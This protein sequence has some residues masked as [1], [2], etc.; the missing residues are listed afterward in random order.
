MPSII[1][2]RKILKYFKRKDVEQKD[3]KINL[4]QAK[5]D[6]KLPRKDIIYTVNYYK[7]KNVLE[8]YP[9]N[10]TNVPEEFYQDFVSI[11]KREKKK[12]EIPSF[13]SG[14]VVAVLGGIILY[15][16]QYL[17]KAPLECLV[18]NLYG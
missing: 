9:P 5:K 1:V 18:K 6:L 10:N 15:I 7:E 4:L 8:Y 17:L 2:R 3:I 16:L 12:I 13:I 11:K 14:I